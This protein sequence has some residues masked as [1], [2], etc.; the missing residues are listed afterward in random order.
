MELKRRHLRKRFCSVSAG[1]SKLWKRALRVWDPGL[2]M[3]D[4]RQFLL[5]SLGG[6]HEEAGSASVG[7][8]QTGFQPLLWEANTMF[9]QEGGNDSEV[10]SPVTAL[11]KNK[12][13][14]ALLAPPAALLAP[15]SASYWQSL[16]GRTWQPNHKARVQ[17]AEWGA[18]NK[19]LLAGREASST[20][21]LIPICF[22]NPRQESV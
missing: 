22:I 7:K 8:I 14:R 21:A 20:S 5:A 16:I 10:T 9:P 6:S 3:G 15:S 19:D 12:V 4:L 13:N 1:V 17:R 18:E 11:G 2:W